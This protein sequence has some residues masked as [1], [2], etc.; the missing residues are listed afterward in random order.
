MEP[1]TPAARRNLR[2]LA[3]H[4]EPV[5]IV[6]QHGLT[7]PVVHEIDAAL[8]AHELVKVRVL[9][10]DRGAREAILRAVATTL[11]C[12]PVQH[13][14][15]V[16]VLWRPNPDGKEALPPI[17]PQAP[18]KARAKKT[19]APLDAVRLRRR[20]NAPTWA[21]KPPGGGTGRRPAAG[22]GASPA[23]AAPRTPRRRRAG[24]A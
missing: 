17:P 4:L 15:K 23:G 16:L 2:A 20:A 11:D 21:P 22:V 10:D 5:V 18:A 3:H 7:P 24:R 13:V 19:P 8:R 14:G 6:G 9:G 1:L 12:A